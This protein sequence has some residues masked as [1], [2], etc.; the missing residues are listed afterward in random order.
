[1][2]WWITHYPAG[3]APS[4]D[5]AVRAPSLEAAKR[6]LAAAINVPLVDPPIAQQG[7][8]SHEPQSMTPCWSA[9]E[10][11]PGPAGS[12]TARLP[13]TSPC[14]TTQPP[15]PGATTSACC[16]RPPSPPSPPP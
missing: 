10:S 2:V 5:Y 14:T 15:A 11:P 9:F 7:D 13:T 8:L 6:K 3:I 4:R 16:P 1:M 12:T